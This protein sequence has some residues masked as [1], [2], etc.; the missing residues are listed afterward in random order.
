MAT[1]TA[2]SPFG[3]VELPL[4]GMAEGAFKPANAVAEL[5]RVPLNQAAV[6]ADP[7]FNTAEAERLARAVRPDSTVLEG[8]G[9]AIQ[10]WDTTRIVKRFG[11]PNF[12]DDTPLNI[13]EALD[14]VPLVL[15]PDEREYVIETARG[16]K[17]FAYA[18]EQVK[19]RRTAMQVVGE[20]PIAGFATSF[21][22]PLWLAVPPAVRVGQLGRVAGRAVSAGISAGIAGGVTAAGEGPASDTD[23]ALSMLM[24]GAA[25]AAF[26]RP[27]KGLVPADPTFPARELNAT[28]EATRVPPS[29]PHYKL[30]DGKPVEVPRELAAGAVNTDQAAVVRATE[31]ALAQDSASRGLGP[32]LMWNMHK[33]MESFGEVGRKVANLLYDNNSDL[34]LTSVEAHQHAIANDLRSPLLDYGDL[35]RQEMGAR[36]AG[37][38]RMLNPFT[39][40]EA[41]AVQGAIEQEVH[42]E[43]LRREQ[44]GRQGVT[45]VAATGDAPP[46]IRAMADK[47]DEVHALALKEQKRSGVQGAAGIDETP[48]YLHRK[49]SSYQMDQV[50]NRL[51]ALGL[52]REVARAKLDDLVALA[53]RRGNAT[54]DR[55]LSQ[56]IGNAIVNRA[57]HKGYFEDGVFSATDSHTLG[58]LRD[59]LKAGGMTT[60]DIE[61]ALNILKVKNDEAGKAGFLKHRLDLDYRATLRVGSENVNIMDLIDS[62]VHTIVDTYVSQV[63]TNSA[64]ARAGLPG[65]SDV[66]ALRKELLHSITDP[67]QR[68][69]AKELFD[70]TVAYM[71]GLPNGAKLNN[72][73]RMMQAFGRTIALAWSGLWQTTEYS[74]IFAQYGLVKSAKYMMQEIPGFKQLL[75]NP[76]RAEARSLNNVLAEHSSNSMRLRPYLAKYEDGYEMDTGSAMQLSLQT[77]GQLVPMANAMKYVHH[78]QAKLIGN[79]IVDRIEMAAKG[80]VKAREALQKFG[81]DY[82]VMD[83]LSAEIQKHGLNVD[84][85]DDAVWDATRPAFA[86]MMDAAV[87]K[88]RLGDMPEFAAFDPVGKLLFTYRSFVLVAHNKVLAGGLQRDGAAAV[89]LLLLYQFPLAMAAVQAQSVVTGK[90][91]LSTE[92]MAKKAMGQM[93]GLGLFS[94]PWKWATGESN[95]VGAPVLIPMD[96]AV[97]LGQSGV[98]LDGKNFARNALSL[99]PVAAASPFMKAIDGQLK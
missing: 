24:N 6:A 36:G 15:S 32:K 77:A 33:T 1:T 28:L 87:L 17:S 44:L 86:K 91:T 48:G 41:H 4:P 57:M 79:L 8:I 25:G 81:L 89:G 54:M 38:L 14:H 23:I 45:D 11:R 56:K 49:W 47:I 72:N 5:N 20:H 16:T 65:R 90:G 35:L 12:E 96:R 69:A 99:L 53:V 51:E 76:T 64:F 9:A 63:A 67:K 74:N 73:F 39:S 7:G 10:S 84:S 55:K 71:R 19:D 93:G 21:L 62:N 82:P 94:E 60:A 95:S 78:A 26:Y 34:S 58:Q 40:R 2:N 43:L 92:D 66:E 52:S 42:R 88:G 3:S 46:A 59:E 37:L 68:E 22:D 70:N 97:K 98:N 29:K 85:W 80:N 83:R 31:T 50:M 61:S 18:L 30:V 13:N 75:E 27:G